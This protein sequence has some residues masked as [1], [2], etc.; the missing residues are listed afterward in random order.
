MPKISVILPIYNVEK[1]IRQALDSV[2]NQ[3]LRDIEIICVNDC[4]PDNSFEIVKEYASKDNR[5]VLLEQET[6]QGQGVARNRAIENA[7]GD[8]IMFLDPDDWYELEACEKAY[9]QISQY[10]NEMV[11]F[12]LFSH[13][14]KRNRFDKKLANRVKVFKQF[15]SNFHI[16]PAQLEEIVFLSPWTWC[17]IYSR[18]FLNKNNI[19]YSNERFLEDLHFFVK[20]WVSAKNISALDEPFY[21]YRKTKNKTFNYALYFEHVLSSKEKAYQ[22]ICESENKDIFLKQFIPYRI[23]SDVSWLKIFSRAEKKIKREFY[24]RLKVLFERINSETSKEIL[25]KSNYYIDFLLIIES[26]SWE[27]YRI[28]RIWK[29]LFK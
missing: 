26:N 5:F 23:D 10:Q 13:I 8:Y 27:E 15:D 1:Y 17:Q 24:K 19:R 12:D 28:K 7:K 29:K 4:T 16:S 9:N 14:E 6:N 2:V 25:M 3:T 20:A 11:F 22:I 18:E 21:N